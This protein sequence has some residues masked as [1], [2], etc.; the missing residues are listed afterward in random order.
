MDA[1]QGWWMESAW[2]LSQD[3]RVALVITNRHFIEHH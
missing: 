1:E 3:G 2:G